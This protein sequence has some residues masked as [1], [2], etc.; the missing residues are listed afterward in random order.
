MHADLLQRYEG[1][2]VAVY[3]GNVVDHD[4]DLLALYLRID[5]KYPD[6]VVLIRQVRPEVERIIH[7]RSPR[8][9]HG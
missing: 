9:E 3:Q 6:D 1:Q 2:H 5:Q 8:F 4:P 7:I